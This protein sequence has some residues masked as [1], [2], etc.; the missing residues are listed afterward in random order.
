MIDKYASPIDYIFWCCEN[1]FKPS[2][3]DILNA[4][5][6]LKSLKKEIQDLNKNEEGFKRYYDYT[7]KMN[8]GY[9]KIGWARINDR[10]DIYDLSSC[11][12]PYIDESTLLP[13][14]SNRLEYQARYGKLSK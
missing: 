12:N 6:E 4:K 8:Q 11:Y 1:D 13:I 3:F 7:L 9:E 14:Y 5:D 2:S 10:G